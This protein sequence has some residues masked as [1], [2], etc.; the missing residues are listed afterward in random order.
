MNDYVYSIKRLMDPRI[1][2]SHSWLFEGKIVGLDALVAKA[3][4]KQYDNVARLGCI[5]CWHL[6]Y[7]TDDAGCQIHHIRHGTSGVA[8]RVD[9]PVI[10]LCFVHHLGNGGIHLLGRKGFQKRYG[11]TE[12]GL[13]QIVSERLQLQ[14]IES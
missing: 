4:K 2:S 1:A 3:K 11:I 6:G 12:E 10:G 5:L 13:L 14:G 7:D 9:A 8:I